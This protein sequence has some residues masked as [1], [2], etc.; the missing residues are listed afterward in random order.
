MFILKEKLG[1]SIEHWKK[2]GKCKF[3]SRIE[4]SVESEFVSFNRIGEKQKCLKTEEKT[5]QENKQIINK[6]KQS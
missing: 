5:K 4:S 1:K 3:E 6:R 2:S